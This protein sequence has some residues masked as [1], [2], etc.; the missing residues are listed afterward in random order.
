MSRHVLVVAAW[1]ICGP[2]AAQLLFTRADSLRGSI[3][4]YRAW[5]DVVNY[6]VTVKPDFASTSIQGTTRIRFTALAEGQHLQI[7]LQQPLE[8]DSINGEVVT[9]SKTDHL[10][11]LLFTRDS[12]VVWVDLP[13]PIAAG[14]SMTLI[15][16][17]HGVPREAPNPPWNGGWIWKTDAQGNPW[18]SVACQGLGASVWYPCKDHQS[19][20]PEGAQ[21]HIVAPDGLVG[22]GNGR[23]QGETSNGDG[24]TTWN[25]RVS[26]PINTYNL[27]PYIGKYVHFDERTLG[28]LGPMTMDF[29]V[30][31]ENEAKAREQF[32]QVPDMMRCFE[33]WLGPYPFYSDG[34]K[35]VEAPHL[36]MEHQSAIAYG[37]R[38][39]NGY[40]GRDLS[41]TGHGLK[42]DYIIVHE[43]GHE[44]FG[45]SITTAD[46]ADMWVHEGF[47]QYTEVLMTECLLG[48]KA[49]EEY[50]IGLRRN[51]RNDE[52]LIGSYG[53]NDEGSG[54]MY[55]K[56]ANLVHMVRHIIGDTLFKRML[57]EM[58]SRY[59]HRIV[60]GAEIEHFMSAC[61]GVDLTKVFDQ[62]L[63]T[64]QVPVLEWG[65]RRKELHF[66]WNDAVD[67]F[68]MPVDVLI[69]GE[70]LRLAPTT[71]WKRIIRPKRVK[72]VEVDKGFYVKD[73]RKK[74]PFMPPPRTLGGPAF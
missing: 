31:E 18:M 46:I 20:E 49:A 9:G 21:L 1:A 25:W 8:V 27:V 39:R 43:S 53:V 16:H 10:Q 35:L 74:P 6:D 61:C 69:D 71:S 52:P 29:W 28:A 60:T 58:N 54:D 30:L 3:G 62:Y 11:G 50:V 32:A 38:F 57:R 33:E 68:D 40:L 23:F 41:G 59:R 15:V 2:L 7:D 19:D 26:A 64:T 73:Q 12:N 22:V 63:R 47:T 72:K 4:P 5:W 13:M 48:P 56:G 66:R 55:P 36:G 24:T 44:W 67:G 42:W 14:T 17:Y 51:I 70:S 34:Y 65:L 37:N 45:N